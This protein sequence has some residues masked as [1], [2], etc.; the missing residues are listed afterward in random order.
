MTRGIRSNTIFTIP[1]YDRQIVELRQLRYF[2]AVAEEHSF[3]RAA[4]RLHI[5]QP[6]LSTQIMMLE[7]ELGVRL[8]DRTN[9]GVSLTAAGSVF[10]E[11]MRAVLVRLE[12]GKTRTQ[13]AG[14]GHVGTLSI[15]F[16]SI[17][18]YGI[19]PPT[20]KEF[21]SRFP[22][23][24]VQL[25]ELTTDA[26]IREM[27]MGRLDLGIALGPIQDADLSFEPLL[28]EALVLALPSRHRLTKKTSQDLRAFSKEDFI[29]PPR[30]IG[31]GLYDLIISR[32]YASGFVPRI[33]QQAR[34]MQTVIS[35]VSAGM[36]VALVPSSV[37]NL[38]RTGVQYAKLKGA[39]SVIDVGILKAQ[40]INNQLHDHFIA[41]LKFVARRDFKPAH[42]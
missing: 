33:T 39:S 32:C 28:H 40:N 15:G 13:Q 25:H 41:T 38:K 27:R 2:I 34:Q 11:E 23:V 5:S 35:L 17:A 21:R 22:E 26:Q 31:P 10:Y 42:S 36:G 7:Q 18:D 20:L 14:L 29:V 9:R 12:H 6:P 24:E 4:E 30:S 1:V 8:L 16:V 3:S 19:L 37:Q